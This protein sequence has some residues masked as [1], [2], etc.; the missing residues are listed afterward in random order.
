MPTV[1][2]RNDGTELWKSTLSGQPPAPKPQQPASAWNHTPQNPTDYKNWGEDET[3]NSGAASNG[4]IGSQAPVAQNTA[5]T[6]HGAFGSSGQGNAPGRN[7]TND[8]WGPSNSNG[9]QYNN[10][11]FFITSVILLRW[12]YYRYTVVCFICR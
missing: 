5:T 1:Q 11:K 9:P 6:P 7:E 10:G 8:F 4:P 3:D 12:Y 2:P